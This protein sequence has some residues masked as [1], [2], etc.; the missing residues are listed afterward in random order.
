MNEKRKKGIE[1]RQAETADELLPLLGGTKNSTYYENC[2]KRI[3]IC[4]T[5]QPLWAFP[6]KWRIWILLITLQSFPVGKFDD[7]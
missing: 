7:S 3:G 4:K 2:Y 1:S 5:I 6:I